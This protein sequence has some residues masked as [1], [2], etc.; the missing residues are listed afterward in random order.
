M[1]M[2]Q[3]PPVGR[4]W[5]PHSSYIFLGNTRYVF[6]VIGMYTAQVSSHPVTSQRK[7]LKSLKS[8]HLPVY[9]PA[10]ANMKLHFIHFY[11]PALPFSHLIISIRFH[12]GRSFIWP[13]IFK[14]CQA[15][16]LFSVWRTQRI[17]GTFCLLF[18]L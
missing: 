3:R 13:G 14:W 4:K 2:G 9:P 6:Y 7:E 11:I 15:G 5:K 1:Q 12:C 17:T 10:G 18:I 16:C 8:A